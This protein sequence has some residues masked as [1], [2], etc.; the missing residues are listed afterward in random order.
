MTFTPPQPFVPHPWLRNP[1]L[2]TI[3]PALFPRK[4]DADFQ[5]A[6]ERRLFQVAHDAHILAHCHWQP[7][8]TQCP[9][10]IVLHGLEGSAE[11]T[12]V[13]A[14]ASKAFAQGFNAIRLNLRNCGGTMNLCRG[15]YNAGLSADLISVAREL[16]SEK[17]TTI[18]AAGFSL[19][20]NIVLKAAG[21]LG[22]RGVELLAGV[23]AISPA[24]DLDLSVQ[25]IEQPENRVYEMWFLR[26]LKQKIEQKQKLFP[27]LY[28]LSLLPKVATLRDFDDVFTGPGAGYSGAQEYYYK[29]S[30]LRVIDQIRV[31]TLIVAAKDDPL[32]PYSMFEHPALRNPHIRLLTTAYG[33][34]AGFVQQRRENS[35]LLDQF[36]AENRVVEFCQEYGS[37][38]TFTS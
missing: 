35:P 12:H 17:L 7:M 13:M 37:N 25:A 28:D 22:L 2:M 23:A 11:S 34:H 32:V 18:F 30:A 20:G 36:W 10:I 1:H 15:L 3:L 9:T 31:P 8:R 29:A 26:T 38:P 27:G 33:G 24:I 19:G 4:F 21:E 6:G 16:Q 14:I 5:N